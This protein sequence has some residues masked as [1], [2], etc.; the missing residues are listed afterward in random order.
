MPW[1]GDGSQ[2]ELTWGSHSLP[3]GLALNQ[4]VQTPGAL[5]PC[6]PWLPHPAWLWRAE[7]QRGEDS[8]W[9]EIGSDPADAGRWLR[10]RMDN[11]FLQLGPGIPRD[12]PGLET[13]CWS[14]DREIWLPA[15]WVHV[16]P[17]EQS[18]GQTM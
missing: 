15:C 12:L 1:G 10:A 13:P 16:S 3:T 18:G 7:G 5:A 14:Q 6:A 11:L 8:G 9:K 2:K 4:E 17:G